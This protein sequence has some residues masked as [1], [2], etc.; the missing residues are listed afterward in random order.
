MTRKPSYDDL[1]RKVGN[2]EKRT[3]TYRSLVEKSQDLFYR[4]DLEGRI[5][6]ISPSVYRLSGYTV[7]EAI[8]MPMAEKVYLVPEERESFLAELGK[9][10]QVTNFEARLRRKDGSVWWAFTSARFYKD[11]QGNILGVEGN[12]RDISDLKKTEDALRTSE[13]KFRLTFNTSPDSI[14]LNRVSDGMYIEINQG[15]TDLTGYTRQDVVGKT[16]YEINIWADTQDRDRLVKGL[17]KTGRVTNLEARFVRKNGDIGVA[18]MSARMLTINDEAII[19]SITRDITDKRADKK[20]LALFA[21]VIK[22][23][24]E[25]VLITDID[26]AI[27]YTNPSLEKNTGYSKEELVGKKPSIL[28]SGLHDPVFY[29]DL[30]STILAKRTWKGLIHNQSKTGQIILHDA[31]ITPILDSNREIIA[32]VSIRRDVTEQVKIEDQLRQ[33]QKMEAIGTLAGGIAHDF[34]NILSGIFGYA[35]LATV[36]LDNPDKSKKHI[37]QIKAGASRAAD[38]VQQIL[39]FSRRGEHQK[40]PVKLYLIVK[41]AIKFLR[42]SIPSNIEIKEKIST[43]STAIA[44]PTQIHQIIMNLCTNASQAMQESGGTLS[45]SLEDVEIPKSRTIPDLGIQAGDYIRMEVSDTGTG[46]DPDTLARIFEPYFTTKEIGK[47]TGLGLAVVLGIVEEYKGFVKAYSEPGSGTTFHVYFPLAK[48]HTRKRGFK[49]P[50]KR[51]E[52]GSGHVMVVDD[53]GDILASTREILQNYGYRVTGF[54]N[55]DQAFDAVRNC[56]DSFD[57]VITDRTMPKMTG[58]VLARELFKIRPDLPVILCSGYGPGDAKDKNTGTGIQKY[59]QKP[60]NSRELI[61]WIQKLTGA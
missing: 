47:G 22:Q 13:E 33:S 41:E 52:K 56:P 59:L 55:G 15:F 6:F 17:M 36:N 38:L 2:L 44:D 42:S 23:A 32:F 16:S 26:G 27:Q 46:M 45:I 9:H 54:P 7:E 57:L 34:N 18:L 28:K 37:Q 43:R 21:A 39:T 60:V 50:K 10:G 48:A 30:W 4:T 58:D 40:N 19:L 11:D 20:Q 14:N 8:G 53:D 5:T 49:S 29:E 31:R 24:N 35:D 51:L 12:T 3:A 61:F 1:L 25:E